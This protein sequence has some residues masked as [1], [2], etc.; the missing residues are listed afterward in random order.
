M[1]AS[2]KRIVIDTSSLIA[3]CIYPDRVPAAIYKQALLR[4][5]LVASPATKTEIEAVLNRKKFDTWRP[6][7]TRMAWLALYFQNI[8]EH[9]PTQ[10]F[11]D[12]ADPKDDM[13]LAIAVAANASAIVCSDPHLLNLHPFYANDSKIDILSLRDFKTVYLPELAH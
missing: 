1:N 13:F 9:V 8:E 2:R 3:V 10:H 4:Y 6:L 7:E 12:S 11:T 5:Q